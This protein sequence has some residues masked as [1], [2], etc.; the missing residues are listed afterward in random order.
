MII[1]S[2]A[3]LLRAEDGSRSDRGCFCGIQLVFHNVPV[4]KVTSLSPSNVQVN[5]REYDKP[6]DDVLQGKMDAGLVEAFVENPDDNR[7][8]QCT[9]HRADPP[10]EADSPDHDSSDGV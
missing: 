5:R 6:L 8:E 2:P 3:L 9:A 4:D 10:G 7:S 1:L